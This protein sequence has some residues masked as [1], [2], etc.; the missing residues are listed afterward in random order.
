[1]AGE[2]GKGILGGAASGAAAGAPFGPYGAAIGAGLGAIS[3][4]IQGASAKKKAAAANRA[5]KAMPSED[6]EQRW[7]LEMVKK[8]Q[9]AL[10][11][12]TDPM[13]AYRTKQVNN[14]G[15]QTQMNVLR[16]SGGNS[17]GTVS[18]ILRAQKGI[19]TGLQE[20][21]ADAA[22]R[23]DQYTGMIGSA[24]GDMANW[25]R[26]LLTHERDKLAADAAYAQQAIDD[27]L[28]AGIAALPGVARG[29]GGNTGSY[30][31]SLPKGYQ[32][33]DLTRKPKTSTLPW[34]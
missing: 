28:A 31:V 21:G 29:I 19:N 9:K 10:D 25:R 33:G 16:A 32:L 27:Q 23:A 2:V 17:A 15:F 6:P 22:S 18:N 34:R 3:G 26:S 11:M 12:G 30:G 7:F 14:A 8:R 4:G 24:I 20:A 5:A 1:M 13:T